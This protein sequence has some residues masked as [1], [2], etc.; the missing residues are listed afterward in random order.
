MISKDFLEMHLGVRFQVASKLALKKCATECIMKKDW[1]ILDS[2][3]FASILKVALS[4][5]TCGYCNG[6]GISQTSSKW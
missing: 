3:T 4:V 5:E 1:P 6:R 2:S